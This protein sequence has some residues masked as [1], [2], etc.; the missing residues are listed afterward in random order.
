MP[1]D[2]EADNSGTGVTDSTLP[3]I[4][5]SATP[6]RET[7]GDA[8]CLGE[9]E[10][11]TTSIK[12]PVRREAGATEGRE[13][14]GMGVGA[15]LIACGFET[16]GGVGATGGLTGIGDICDVCSFDGIVTVFSVSLD[17]SEVFGTPAISEFTALSSSSKSKSFTSTPLFFK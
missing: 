14:D 13:I 10:G 9:A 6:W 11:R 5:S 17:G 2:E 15:D 12:R 1:T 3:E 8:S 7:F 4:G 16:T